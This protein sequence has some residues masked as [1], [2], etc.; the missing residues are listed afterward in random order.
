MGETRKVLNVFIAS[1]GDLFEERAVFS[2]IVSEVNRIKANSLGIHLEPLGWEDTLPGKGRPQKLI[3]EDIKRSDLIVMLLWKRWGTSTGKYTSGFEEEYELANSLNEKNDGRPE[4][5]LYFRS[6]PDPML[7]DP[8]EQLRKVL[9]FRSKIEKEKKFLYKAY[10][11]EKKWEKL[12]REHLCRW[13]DEFNGGKKGP[14]GSPSIESEALVSYVK[15]AI[16][17]IGDIKQILVREAVEKAESGQIT[18][19]EEYFAKATARTNDL[20]AL[21][22]Y[23]K[24]L[25]RIGML[26]RAEEKLRQIEN[27]GKMIGDKA[28]VSVAYGNLGN[29]YKT[30]GDLKEAEEMYRKS[31]AIN[32]EL[33]RKEGMANAYCNLGNIYMT[34][35]NLK[36]AEELYG[37]SLKLFTFIGNKIMIKK[38]ESLI[39]DLKRQN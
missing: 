4:M 28:T 26:D 10:E 8:G 17:D 31:L 20:Q 6:I 27:I 34:R 36:E 25:F 1:P 11:D 37:K 13:L 38:I 33:G 35:G 39:E 12:I 2:E 7:A 32:E 21:N 29:I 23:A 16:E 24:F 30:R 14:P 3:N 18:K 22:L 9:D 15:E 19:A 5:C